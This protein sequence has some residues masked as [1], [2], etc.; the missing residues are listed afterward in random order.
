M[1]LIS[2]SLQGPGTQSE[3]NNLASMELISASIQGHGTQSESNNL[4]SMELIS[5][6]LQ[7][8]VTQSESNNVASMELILASLQGHGTQRESNDLAS[9][10]LI[11]ASLQGHGIQSW[12]H[13]SHSPIRHWQKPEVLGEKKSKPFANLASSNN[14]RSENIISLLYFLFTKSSGQCRR[15]DST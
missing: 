5:A 3:S 6:S 13:A 2:V 14:G 11:S 15:H 10:E 12:A 7:G 4:A 8:L 9:M 1:E